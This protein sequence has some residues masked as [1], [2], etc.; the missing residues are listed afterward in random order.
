[1]KRMRLFNTAIA[2]LAGV[3]AMAQAGE[4]TTSAT[5]GSSGRGPGTA[6]ATANYAGGGR[7]Y[8]DTHTRSGKVNLARGIAVGFDREG[9]S[10]STSYAVAGRIGPA[11]A[12]T[13]NLQIGRNGSVSTGV[14]HTVAQGDRS[15]TVSASGGTGSTRRSTPA[16]ATATGQTGPRGSVRATTATRH[17]PPPHRRALAR[18]GRTVWKRVRR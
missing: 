13:F 4:A 1:M 16:W 10:L 8:A 12:G 18:P 14:G 7:G 17:R 5:A 3:A 6:A 11:V 9:L 15:R 2:V